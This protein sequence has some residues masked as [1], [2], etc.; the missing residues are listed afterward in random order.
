[1]EEQGGSKKGTGKRK[2]RPGRR[3]NVRPFF[4]IFILKKTK[5]QKYMS[6]RKIFENGCL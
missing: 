5:F 4:F 6:N 3:G 1:M 2:C